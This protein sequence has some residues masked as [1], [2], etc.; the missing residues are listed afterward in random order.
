MEVIVSKGIVDKKCIFLILCFF[1]LYI[2]GLE[3]L[4]KN[5]KVWNVSSKEFNEI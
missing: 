1:K 5:S 4:M 2:I 3:L